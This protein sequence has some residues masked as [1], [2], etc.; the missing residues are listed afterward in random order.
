MIGLGFLWIH[1]VKG[2]R[3]VK[4][5]EAMATGR[6]SRSVWIHMAPHCKKKAVLSSSVKLQSPG[7]WTPSLSPRN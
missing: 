2:E 5:S 4:L 1:T 3:F 7:S 6:P